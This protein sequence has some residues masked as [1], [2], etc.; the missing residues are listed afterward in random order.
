MLT[1]SLG[2]VSRPVLLFGGCTVEI[3]LDIVENLSL[4]RYTLVVR[5]SSMA[6]VKSICWC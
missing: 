1:C 6:S 5:E 3:R 2:V 4:G